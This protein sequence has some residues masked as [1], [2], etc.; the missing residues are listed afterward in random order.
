M[1]AV[2]PAHQIFQ[3]YLQHQNVEL[4]PV[5][6]SLDMGAFEFFDDSNPELLFLDGFEL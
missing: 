3:Q 4:R 6:G 1:P 2:L 5:D